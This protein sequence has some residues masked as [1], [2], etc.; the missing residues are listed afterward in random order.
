MYAYATDSRH[1]IAANSGPESD[2]DSPVVGTIT[3]YGFLV[4]PPIATINYYTLNFGTVPDG[5]VSA[6]PNPILINNGGAPMSYSYSINGASEFIVDQDQSTCST[7]GTL[8]PNT[9]CEIYVTF[10][11]AAGDNGPY[12]ATLTWTDDSLG[13]SGSMQSI[14][15]TGTAGA[16]GVTPPVFGENP[17]N[18][19]YIQNPQFAYSD[20]DSN[21]T[22]YLCSFTTGMTISP[23]YL[24]CSQS[25]SE[26]NLS[27]NM[28]YTFAVEAVDNQGNVSAPTF[29]TWE[30]IPSSVSVTFAGS[31]T[32]QV[33]STS[34][35]GLSCTS[36][37]SVPF[38]G[39]PVTI[40]ATPTGGS[41]FIGW[42]NE[43]NEVGNTCTGTTNPCVLQS[44]D[45]FQIVT[46]TFDSCSI[47]VQAVRNGIRHRNRRRH[48]R[49]HSC[50]LHR[51]RRH[52]L[53]AVLEYFQHSDSHSHGNTATRHHVH[54][55][56][57]RLLRHRHDVPRHHE[58]QDERHGRFHSH[59]HTV[60]LT[61]V[62]SPGPE[63]MQA[64]YN[65]P[66]NPNPTPSNP[67]NAPFAYALNLGVQSVS[68]QFT[69][70]VL[71][72]EV[73]PSLADGICES[74]RI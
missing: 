69:V 63:S 66:G 54:R 15:F 16:S 3:S 34:P 40:M 61:F 12:T 14:G 72:T 11:P 19:S 67:C 6:S 39:V 52:C 57:R 55:L 28:Y 35:T 41:T 7:S 50:R 24:P 1:G 10:N 38:D 74:K 21:V 58:L 18:P 62:T 23:N 31:G 20:T 42:S 29:Q 4:A 22:S 49:H 51:G 47:V 48:L 45:S 59:P 32:G 13:V 70:N 43:Y 56:G 27:E 17:G 33:T 53:P 37:C 68:S 9:S 5:G 25:F 60:P 64:T 36:N 26:S 73:P 71:A 65:C 8:A 44:G 46:A 2:E 30:V